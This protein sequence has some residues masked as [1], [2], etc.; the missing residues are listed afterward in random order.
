MRDVDV[1][2]VGAGPAGAVTAINLAPFRRVLLVE[3]R[4][5]VAPRVGESLV[6]AARRLFADMGLLESF[7]RE[8][9]EPWYG[10]RS[11]WGSSETEERDFLRDPDGH[12]WHLD[13]RRFESWLRALAQERGAELLSPATLDVLQRSEEKWLLRLKTDTNAIEVSACFVIDAGGQSAPVVRKLGLR[14][15]VLENLVCCYVYGRDQA[16]GARGLTYVEAVRN[17]WFYTAPIPQGRRILA[18][19]TDADLHDKRLGVIE[20]LEEATELSS[21]LANVGFVPDDE[22]FITSARSAVLDPAVGEGWLAVGDAAISFDPLSSQGL[23]NA[24]F[25]GLAAAEAVDS[26]LNGNQLSLTQYHQTIG[27]IFE[28]YQQK[29]A[30]TYAAETRWPDAPFWQR[31]TSHKDF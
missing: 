9:H 27:A 10:N 5:E 4:L 8:Q 19:H 1:V 22:T 31:R 17:G 7:L 13:R 16:T 29:L 23:F 30:A 6:P 3:R 11:V 21:L 28:A 18:F 24:L 26:Y 2:I 12:G 25:T 20:C 14:A 15:K